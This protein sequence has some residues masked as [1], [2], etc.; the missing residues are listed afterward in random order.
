MPAYNEAKYISEVAGKAMKYADEVLVV[1]DGSI[2]YTATTAYDMGCTVIAHDK[3]MG[4]GIAKITILNEVRKRDFDALVLIDS[5][6]QHNPAE[7]PK[8]VNYVEKGYDLVLGHRNNKQI[9]FLRFVG[10][11]VLSLFTSLISRKYINDSQCGFRALSPKAVRSINLTEKGMA[12]ESEMIYRACQ[13]RL[14]IIEIPVSVTYGKDTS[15]FNPI[16][17]GT[18]V[19]VRIMVIGIKGLL[20][21]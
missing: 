4:N 15:T 16:K 9:P 19:L 17:H 8:L 1:D 13:E 6:G 3:N 7:I 10:N 5:D 14:R 2:D 21:K 11:A 12:I 18:Y 20:G